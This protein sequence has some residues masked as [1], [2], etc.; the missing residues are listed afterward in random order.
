MVVD[1]AKSIRV[2]PAEIVLCLMERKITKEEG[3]KEEE[4]EVEEEEEMTAR[5]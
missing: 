3:G 5:Q 1:E 4:E 2:S